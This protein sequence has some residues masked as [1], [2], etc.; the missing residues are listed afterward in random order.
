MYNLSMSQVAPLDRKEYHGAICG[1][2][3]LIFAMNPCP[4]GYYSDLVKACT[5]SN[6]N[7]TRYQK[8]ISGTLLDRIDIHIEVPHVEYEKLSDV[9]LGELSA[10][11]RMRV[12]TDRQFQRE[13]F[14]GHE[15]ASHSDPSKAQVKG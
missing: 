12:K 3:M 13:R 7:I 9:R 2:Y 11:V 8:R 10:D 14:V 5:S 4:C 6:S 15:S 1:D